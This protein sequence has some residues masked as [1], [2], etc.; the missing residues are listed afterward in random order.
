MAARKKPKDVLMQ[1]QIDYRTAFGTEF[2]ER[3]L[4]DLADRCCVKRPA[5]TGDPWAAV[6]N[7]GMRA[8]YLHIQTMI[9]TDFAKLREL[10][11]EVE[12]GDDDF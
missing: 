7:D 10:M 11:K 12:A 4:K 9:E 6:F 3:V 2:G 5:F 8:V 1:T